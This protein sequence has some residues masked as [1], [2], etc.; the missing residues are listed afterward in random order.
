MEIADCNLHIYL[1]GYWSYVFVSLVLRAN[2][3]REWC[4]LKTKTKQKPTT[5]FGCGSALHKS[6]SYSN[7]HLSPNRRKWNGRSAVVNDAF[8]TLVIHSSLSCYVQ[9]IRIYVCR[10]VLNPNGNL[11]L[12]L[13]PLSLS[14]ISFLFISSSS[15]SSFFLSSVFLS[16]CWWLFGCFSTFLHFSRFSL[17]NANSVTSWRR[18]PVVHGLCVFEF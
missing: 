7:M 1:F 15:L 18:W 5:V 6:F 3:W 8:A 14:F 4:F 16:H 13:F 9:R 17:C 12:S 2:V 11:R 10:R